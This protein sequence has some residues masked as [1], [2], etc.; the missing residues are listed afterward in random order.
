[1]ILV[2]E[3][4][5]A[6]A[7]RCQKMAAA[8]IDSDSLARKEYGWTSRYWTN[9]IACGGDAISHIAADLC[10]VYLQA[11]RLAMYTRHVG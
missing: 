2:G 7:Y 8:P 9:E 5:P 3:F 4:V 10:C 11:D 6:L 1:M